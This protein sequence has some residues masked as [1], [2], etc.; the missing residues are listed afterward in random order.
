MPRRNPADRI[1]RSRVTE[2][3][4]FPDLTERRTLRLDAVQR[5]L[6]RSHFA[7][8]H[9]MLGTP[10]FTNLTGVFSPLVHVE[11]SVDD[12][13]CGL[14]ERLLVRGEGGLARTLDER[15]ALRHLIRDGRHEVWV[16]DGPRLATAR[17]VNVF[18]R[19]D[20]DPVRRRVMEL[21]EAWGLG[22]GPSRTAEVPSLATLVP[23]D[24][25]PDLVDVVP[26]VWHFDQ[27]D[28]NR[29]VNGNEYLRV[30]TSWLSD[31]LHAAGH[32]LRRL[33]P[34]QARIVYRKPCF[35]GEGYRRVAWFRGEAPLVLAGAFQKAD[36]PPGAMPAAAVELTFRQHPAPDA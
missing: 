14:G 25:A 23:G 9:R 28:A 32:D 3:L 29:H 11:L 26:H 30:M 19:Y 17:L 31:V 6:G 5:Y 16:P 7:P 8:W 27:T 34:A 33:W 1:V 35:R 36:D 15:G 4:H 20:A 24:R 2:A 22:P 12:V 21:P 10:D 13:A 18:T